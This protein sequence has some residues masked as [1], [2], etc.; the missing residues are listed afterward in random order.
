MNIT[1]GNIGKLAGDFE[2]AKGRVTG[3]AGENPFG[4]MDTSDGISS[5]LGSFTSGMQAELAAAAR[6]MTATSEALRDAAKVTAET[7]EAARDSLTVH[8]PDDM[9]A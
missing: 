2:T 6:L 9:R 4:A 1:A 8:N 7:D 5:A 3:V